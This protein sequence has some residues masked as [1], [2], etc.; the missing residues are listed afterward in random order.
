MSKKRVKISF[1]WWDAV[2]EID[3]TAATKTAMKE[4]LLFWSGGQ[5]R[6]DD[7]DGDI[8]K[9][10]LTMLG[11]HIIDES[12]EW[13]ADGIKSQYDDREGWADLRGGCGVELISCDTWIFSDDEF[14]FEKK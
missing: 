4:Q 10:Y 12:I 13:N 6:I 3:D 5:S 9:A 2:V 7:A 1:D 11:Q 14:N 8:E